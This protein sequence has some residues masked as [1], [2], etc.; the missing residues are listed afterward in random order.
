MPNKKG[1]ASEFTDQAAK[2]KGAKRRPIGVYLKNDVHE[3]L[4]DIAQENDQTLHGMIAYAVADFIKRYRTG[5]VKI[6]TQ[7]KTTLKTDI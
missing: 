2:P 3:A 1:L 6:E 4:Q 7:T 5:K